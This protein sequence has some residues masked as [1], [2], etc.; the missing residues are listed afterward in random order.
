MIKQFSAKF[1]NFP[2]NAIVHRV[3][4]VVIAPSFENVS[5]LVVGGDF[6]QKDRRKTTKKDHVANIIGHIFDHVARQALW[7]YFG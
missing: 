6:V 3:I 4:V 2:F 5:N 1:R 7:P